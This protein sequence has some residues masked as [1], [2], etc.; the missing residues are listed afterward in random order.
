MFCKWKECKE[1]PVTGSKYCPE[2]KQA[3]KTA[4]LAKFQE[5]A[6]AKAKRESDFN[7]IYTDAQCAAAA[8]FEECKPEPMMVQQ[9]ES[10][11]DD[12]TP[13]TKQWLVPEGV[14]GFASVIVSP[15]TCSFAHWIKKHNHGGGVAYRWGGSLRLI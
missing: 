5:A 4:M 15:G 1:S 3:A 6:Q 11:V 14:C 2:H 10:P 8:A 7:R 13:V 9:H 12:Q